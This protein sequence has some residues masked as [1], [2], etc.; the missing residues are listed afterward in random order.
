MR[1][2]EKGRRAKYIDYKNQEESRNLYNLGK[3]ED[4]ANVTENRWN[5]MKPGEAHKN[6][7][8][9]LSS[10]KKLNERINRKN[11]F[12]LQ[13]AIIGHTH[14]A[15]IAVDDS[16]EKPFF[17]MDCGA[18]LKKSKALVKKDGEWVEEVVDNA[19][20]GVLY[21]NDARIYQL[22]PLPG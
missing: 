19:Q 18:W 21:K 3:L 2:V 8:S 10:A 15:R 20:I 1:K 22:S 17:L 9:R 16:G 4:P 7:L 5:L 14:K 12:Q 13:M 6:Q 11:D